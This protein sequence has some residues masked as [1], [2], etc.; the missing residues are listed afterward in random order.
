MGNYAVKVSG[1]IGG[2]G[3]NGW[4]DYSS[5]LSNAFPP[6]AYNLSGYGVVG[7]QFWI[8]GD[9]NTYR[10]DVDSASVTDYDPYGFQFTPPAG[11]WTF[12]QIPF[13]TMTAGWAHTQTGLPTNPT[14][15][16]I[17]G[18]EFYC[19]GATAP[20][21]FSY[22]L[23]Q[24]AFYTNLELTPS[25]T[26]TSTSTATRTATLTATSSPTSTPTWTWTV[27]RTPS[28]TPSPTP[29]PTPT[30]VSCAKRVLAFYVPGES[31]AYTSNTIPYNELTHL[32]E[33]F[34][35]VN[36]A[37]DGSITVPAGYV[38]TNLITKAHAAGVKVLAAVG[39]ADVTAPFISIAANSTYMNTFGTN[40]A[41]FCTTNNYDGIDI[42]WEGSQTDYTNAVTLMQ[43]LRNKLTAANP[44]LLLSQD[45]GAG[46]W[47]DVDLNLTSL[48]TIVSF[49]NVMTYSG[50][51]GWNSHTSYNDPVSLTTNPYADATCQSQ[52]DYL[53]V[54][55]GVPASLLNMGIGFYG[56]QFN[57]ESAIN[58]LCAAS[59]CTSDVNDFGYNAISNLVG[60]SS[61]RNWD[62]VAL[63]PYLTN[64][65]GTGWITYDDAQA[66]TLK[67]NYALTTRGA[68]GVF[69]WD[70]SNDY[71]DPGQ[72]PL[73]TAMYQAVQS[74][75]GSRPPHPL[76]PPCLV[77]PVFNG[78]ETLTDRWR[79][80][81]GRI[82]TPRPPPWALS[83]RVRVV[84][85]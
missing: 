82:A 67:V 68:G 30:T 48:S 3:S 66:V 14:A 4:T 27:T 84:L 74:S 75:A 73:M 11:V 85:S 70:I 19:Y 45:I 25:P 1:L 81:G 17:T 65:D 21:N 18:V 53:T 58:V 35:T 38:D 47:G 16:D 39:G 57:S 34:I 44:A 20:G 54:T 63:V 41:N 13:S 76:R 8:Y 9:G 12:E 62:P 60:T 28:F 15:T 26:S 42:D 40:L 69:M 5:N 50:A 33:S 29:S 10:V 78:C 6:T 23:D 43:T 59:N 2:S 31:A 52:M 36:T 37:G 71:I 72:Q 51:G 64:N 61:T 56:V 77:V 80:G 46:N 24:L 22:E 79:G 7:I 32:C 83:P 55:R 49:F